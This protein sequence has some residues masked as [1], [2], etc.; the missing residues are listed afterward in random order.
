MAELIIYWD[1]LFIYVFWLL[2]FGLCYVLWGHS[3]GIYFWFFSEMVD[4]KESK[5]KHE[6]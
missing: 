1:N 5:D 3:E 2:Y 4:N 6:R